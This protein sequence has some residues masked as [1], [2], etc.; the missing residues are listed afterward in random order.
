MTIDD[1]QQRALFWGTG[2]SKENAPRKGVSVLLS[3]AALSSR[4]INFHRRE[5]DKADN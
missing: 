2:L 3:P 4:A 5:T 1:K